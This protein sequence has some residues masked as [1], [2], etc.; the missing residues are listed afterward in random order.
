MSEFENNVAVYA[1]T[2]DPITNGHL[3]ILERAISVF[4]IVYLAVATGGPRSSP[5]ATYFTT[6]ERLRLATKSVQEYFGEESAAKIRVESFSGMLVDFAVSV[7]SKV[8]VRGLRAVSDYEYE[9]QLAHT[10]RLLCPSIET[11]FFVTSGSNSFIS[12][13][14]VRNIALNGGDIS[15]IVPRPVVEGFS[16]KQ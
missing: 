8:I 15:A 4:P 2:F 3:D 16:K 6:K 12:S 10:N 1:G 5:K 7:N 9:S 11:I 13:S 14:I